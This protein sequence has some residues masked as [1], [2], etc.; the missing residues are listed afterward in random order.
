MILVA[1]ERCDILCL[2]LPRAEEL[3]RRRL[4]A[5][6]AERAAARARAFADPTRLMLAAS[7]REGDELC[8]CDLA[9]I[10]GRPQNLV[11][12]HLRAL[13]QEGL[14]ESRRQGKIVFYSLTDA[15]AALFD[16]VVEAGAGLDTAGAA[17]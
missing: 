14:A 12:H 2:D 7:L 10:S 5:G 3:R 11:S 6:A 8:V 4:G 9:W 15:G 17:R 16:R 1:D 13:R